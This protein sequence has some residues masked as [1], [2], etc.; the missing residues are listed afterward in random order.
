M[1][2]GIGQQDHFTY[3]K[4]KENL[5]CCLCFSPVGPSLRT[6]ATRFPA[7]SNCTV[8]DWFQPWPQQALASVGKKL[9]ADVV[10]E[11]KDVKLAVETFIRITPSSLRKQV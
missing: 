6:R 4:I 8:I 3:T 11:N 1:L 10:I 5:H 9:L 2:L 7:L